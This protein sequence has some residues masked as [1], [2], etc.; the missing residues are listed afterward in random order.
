MTTYTVRY[1]DLNPYDP[2]DRYQVNRENVEANT[3]EDAEDIM[4]LAGK[5]VIDVKLK[6]E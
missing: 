2:Q 6:E 5:E 3:A 4:V 1:Y